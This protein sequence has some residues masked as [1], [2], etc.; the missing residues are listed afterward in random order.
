MEDAS[1]G[2]LAEPAM[3][4]SR[5]PDP[6]LNGKDTTMAEGEGMSPQEA[7]TGTAGMMA[8]GAAGTLGGGAFAGVTGMSIGWVVGFLIGLLVG[9]SVGESKGLYKGMAGRK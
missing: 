9:M 5:R 1:L 6:D 7:S 8:G 3:A 2:V 4:G